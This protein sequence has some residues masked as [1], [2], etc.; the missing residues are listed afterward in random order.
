MTERVSIESGKKNIILVAPHSPDDFKTGEIVRKLQKEINSYAVI[1]NGFR[2]S[3]FVDSENDLAD[4]NRLDHLN[5]FVVGAEF[6]RPIIKFRNNI[7][8]TNDFCHIFY[9]HGFGR[10]VISEGRRVDLIIGN[11]DSTKNDESLTCSIPRR[12]IL[13]KTMKEVKFIDTYNTNVSQFKKSP[14][15]AVALGGEY[16]AK[17]PNNLCQYFASSYKTQ[18]YQI[19]VHNSLRQNSNLVD[20]FVV[21]FAEVL[22]KLEFDLDHPPIGDFIAESFITY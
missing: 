17:S 21:Y 11:G 13:Y 18:A 1:N 22:D 7:L 8:K 5:D 10:K 6:L 12:K 15:V 14:I 2:R 4:C 16:G 3:T 9:I 19:E 20:Q